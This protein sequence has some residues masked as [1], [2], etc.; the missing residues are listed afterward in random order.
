MKK[1]HWILLAVFTYLLFLIAYTPA[2]LVSELIHKQTNKQ[3]TL[4]GVNGTLFSG[5]AEQVSA[6]GIHVNNV[7]WELSPLSLLM[8]KAKLDVKGGNIRNKDDIYV[9]GKLS[10]SLLSP[11]KFSLQNASLFVPTKTLLS[12]I[13]LPVF[14][15]ASGRFRVDVNE[16][17]FDEGCQA[18][19]GKGNWLEAAVN[20]NKK[21]ID[22]GTFEAALSC[23][24]P[25]FAVQILPGN[26]LSLDAN[27]SIAL[28]GKYKV[29]G[30]YAI[31]NSLPKEI[32]EAARFFGKPQGNG[33]Y[34]ISF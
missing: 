19:Q 27:L 32:Q 6:Q 14:V 16:L 20:V 23:D 11:E 24:T 5:S 15:T 3:V 31:D 26:R 9:K 34:T 22:F 4:Y 8:L 1:W 25:G 12:Q 13:K 7:Q 28:N 29:T 30:E 18:L 10:A 33:R 17:E 2:S 21:E